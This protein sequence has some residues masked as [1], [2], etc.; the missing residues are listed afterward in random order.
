V[1]GHIAPVCAPASGS[2]FAPG[3]TTVACTA[4]DKAG[5]VV[6]GSFA[7]AYAWTGLPQPINADGSSI[8]KQGS[9]APAK[10]RL[11][12]A[13]AGITDLVARLSVAPISAAVAGTEQEAVSTAAPDAGSTFRYDAASGQ[14]VLNLSTKALA[15]GT[16]R[17]RVDLGDGTTN[18]ATIPLK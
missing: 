3:T 2:T 5:N 4:T 12:G 16:Y 6:R 13:S 18:A 14:Y 10:F 1:D 9:T 11:T 15:V 8:F 7:V 17:V